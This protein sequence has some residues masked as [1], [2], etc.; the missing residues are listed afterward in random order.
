MLNCLLFLNMKKF[1]SKFKK[2][3]E[4][5]IADI[6]VTLFALQFCQ[7][8]KFMVSRL[9]SF[10][11]GYISWFIFIFVFESK[12]AFL[13]FALDLRPGLLGWVFCSLMNDTLLPSTWKGSGTNLIK[14]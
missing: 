2:F 12:L 7:I 1:D 11:A 13:V 4:N 14:K 9:N 5:Q 10:I 8:P 3:R 6:G